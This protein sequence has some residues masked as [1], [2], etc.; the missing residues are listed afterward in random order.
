[1]SE[2]MGKITAGKYSRVLV[3]DDLSIT[4]VSP[5]KK[6]VIAPDGVLSQGA[7]DQLYLVARFAF[8]KVLASLHS[9]PLIIL[10]DPFQSFDE[11]RRGQARSLLE[12]LSKEFQI[13]LLTHS[14]EYDTW[15]VVRH[16]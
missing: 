7:L 1:M 5:E 8:L 6:E 2:F 10:D 13:L 12:E 11:A 4:V 9:R 14:P 16:L 3:G 15:G